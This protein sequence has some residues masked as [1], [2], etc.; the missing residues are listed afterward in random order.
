MLTTRFNFRNLPPTLVRIVG[1]SLVVMFSSCATQPPRSLM[2]VQVGDQFILKQSIPIRANHTRHFIQFGVLS[3]S[4]FNHYEP[5]CRI[6][7]N[8]LRETASLI[9]P[10]HF[11]IVRVALDE[12]RIANRRKPNSQPIYMAQNNVLSVT[13]TDA[14]NNQA[15]YA[16]RGD[17]ERPETMDIVHL[18]LQSDRQPDVLRLTCSSSLSDG[19]PKDA[20]QS[21]RPQLLQINAILGAVGQVIPASR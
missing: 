18:Y 6:E 17:N 4:G 10:D 8:T 1:L 13:K 15:W 19:N 21:Y 5:H 3:G 7:I 2:D 12:E 14:L 11:K 16:L 9:T 20:P